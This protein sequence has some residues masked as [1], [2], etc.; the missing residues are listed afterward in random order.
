MTLT[1]KGFLIW[2]IR[3]VEGGRSEAIAEKAS[4]AGLTHVLIKIADGD[5][6]FGDASQNRAVVNALRN[7]RIQVWGWH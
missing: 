3:N 2:K 4:R 7:H 1:G 5:R 6:R